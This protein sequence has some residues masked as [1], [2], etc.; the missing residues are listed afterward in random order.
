MPFSVLS[1]GSMT[2]RSATSRVK[3]YEEGY[4]EPK[5]P[6]RRFDYVDGRNYH[7][8]NNKKKHFLPCDDEELERL[9]VNTLLFRLLFPKRIFAP[10]EEDLKRGIRV[11][12][13]CAGPGFW[14]RDMAE[15]Y[16]NSHFT[17]TDTVIY[18]V[19]N[20]RSNCHFRIADPTIELP[21]ADNSFDYVVQHDAIYHYTRA[22]WDKVIQE[23]IR[24]TKPGGFLD[25]METSDTLQDLGPNFSVWLMRL[26]VSMQ[27]RDIH[28]KLATQLET[29]LMETGLVRVLEASHRSAPIGWLGKLGDVALESVQRLFDSMKPRLCED[30]SMNPHKYD[31]IVQTAAQE[32]R[33]FKSWMNV[34]YV[35]CQKLD[36]HPSLHATASASS[37]S[38]A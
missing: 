3:R 1:K 19:S 2:G 4:E 12:S 10:V 37:R 38:H 18:P 17:G 34:Y 7:H 20:S 32:C 16:P 21:F 8:S 6:I 24:V 31:K 9:E 33:E 28:F 35:S 36:N 11:L 15:L 26:T 27:T 29:A 22:E 14:L 30:W 5:F 25:Y 23:M 13:V